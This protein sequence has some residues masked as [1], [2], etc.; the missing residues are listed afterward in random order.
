MHALSQLTRLTFL[1]LAQLALSDECAA[2]M[3][4]LT[5]LRHLDCHAAH[6]LNDDGLLCMEPAVAGL[7]YLDVAWT[8]VTLLPLLPCLQVGW[9]GW[10]GEVGWVGGLGSEGL[11]RRG[12]SEEGAGGGR[13]RKRRGWGGGQV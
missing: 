6:G 12:G 4:A 9:G 10:L 2:H 13:Q 8:G 3:R 1:G 11:G 7:T 5:R